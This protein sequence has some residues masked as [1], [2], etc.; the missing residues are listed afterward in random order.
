[1]EALAHAF[2]PKEMAMDPVTIEGKAPMLIMMQ[3]MQAAIL[4]A[5]GFCQFS[6]SG[7]EP[8]QM[9][10]QLATAT[11]VGYT[12]DEVVKIGEKI[13]NLQRLFNLKAGLTRADDCLPKRFLE[14]P[15]PAG[16]GK[17]SVVDLETM[18]SQYY[19]MRGWDEN[20]VPSPEQ[21]AELG[22]EE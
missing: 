8:P 1:M 11:G 15:A 17:G 9:F 20:G 14:E 22:L 10:A 12:F 6:L 5:G 7:Q 16:P 2:G 3:D 18:L 4:D 13:W 21:L 19:M